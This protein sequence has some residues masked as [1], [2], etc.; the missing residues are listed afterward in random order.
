MLLPFCTLDE[1]FTSHGESGSI[2]SIFWRLTGKVLVLQVLWIINVKG[3]NNARSIKS[4]TIELRK[5]SQG[6]I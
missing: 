5:P 6:N 4:V 3:S 1:I 2:G